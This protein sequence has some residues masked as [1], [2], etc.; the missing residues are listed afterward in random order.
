MPAKW[1]QMPDVQNGMNVNAT[2]Q[3]SQTGG[4]NYPYMKVLA[5][6]FQC[7]QTGPITDVHIWGSWLNDVVDPNVVF[8]LSF[9]KDIPGGA[10]N[11]SQPGDQIWMGTFAPGRYLARPWAT[12]PGEPFFD[13]NTNSIIGQDNTIWQYNF[14][15]P[16]T[17]AFVQQGTAANPVVYWLDVQALTQEY[18]S[19]GVP[20][21]VFGWKT[22]KQH[23]NDDAAWA[24]TQGPLLPPPIGSWSELRDPAT[25]QSL[26]LAFVITPEPATLSLLALGGLFLLRR[27]KGNA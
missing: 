21:G 24:D 26:D 10:T 8:K 6:D 22:S 18:T 13:P 11:P 20:G 14:D 1:I 25:Q 5:D 17:E 19:P 12:S 27:R 16:V 23:W 3:A 15:I 2:W 4:P 9:H 7:T